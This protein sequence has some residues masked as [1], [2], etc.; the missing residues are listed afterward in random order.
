MY[1]KKRTEYESTKSTAYTFL[2]MGMI[3][4]V[5]CILVG[6]DVIKL[7]MSQTTKI[8]MCVVL[9]LLFIIFIII[10]IWHFRTLKSL[11]GEVDDDEKRTADIRRWFLENYS[12]EKIDDNCMLPD[13]LS[14]EQSYFK[15]Y[16]YMKQELSMK[17][18]DLSE[19]YTEYILEELY[20]ETYQG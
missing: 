9:S 14:E 18:P 12:A 17:Y 11:S 8:E 10:G 7:P 1:Q 15:R 19:E 20:N 2:P 5:L 13:N 4:L 3:G 6:F 16:E